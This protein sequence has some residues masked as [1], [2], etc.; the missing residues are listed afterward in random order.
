MN[1]YNFSH[2]QRLNYPSLESSSTRR[3]GTVAVQ[4]EYFLKWDEVQLLI[5]GG[6]K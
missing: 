3:T 1:E 4:S 2:N 5:E 6:S